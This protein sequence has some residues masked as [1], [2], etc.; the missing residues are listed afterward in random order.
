MTGR[1]RQP[2][3]WENEDQQGDMFFGSDTPDNVLTLPLQRDDIVVDFETAPV[4]LDVFRVR[5]MLRTAVEYADRNLLAEAQEL[6]DEVVASRYDGEDLNVVQQRLHSLHEVAAERARAQHAADQALDEPFT[7]RLPGRSSLSPAVLR[8]LLE[9]DDDIDHQRLWS[10]LDAT[11][12]M[13]AMAPAYAPAWVRL[14]EL[15]VALGQDDLA[16]ATL[17]ELRAIVGDED[18]DNWLNLATRSLLDPEDIDV[19]VKL[20]RAVL[21]TGDIELMDAYVSPAITQVLD[22][23]PRLA[24]ELADAFSAARP[25]AAGARTLRLRALVANGR[26]DDALAMLGSVG[27]GTVTSDVMIVKAAAA[28]AEGRDAWLVA[29]EEASVAAYQESGHIEEIRRAITAAATLIPAFEA[30]IT[31]GV[32]LFAAGDIVG[33]SRTFTADLAAQTDKHPDTAFVAAAGHALCMQRLHAAD[34][35][36]PLTTAIGQAVVQ[37]VRRYA[38]E[39]RIFPA[40]V[41]PDSLMQLLVS[42]AR[43]TDQVPEAV[44]QLMVLR[45]RLPEHL[46]IR[47]GLA[48]LLIT[49]DRVTDGVRELRY[50]AERHE[51]AGD[52]PRMI[53]AMQRMSA[54][55]PNNANVKAKLIDGFL[56]RG[57]PDEA[58]RELRQL[59]DLQVRRGRGEEGARAFARGAEIALT[60]MNVRTALDLFDRAVDADPTNLAVRH[61]TVAGCITAGQA[62]RAVTQLR[63]IVR[64]SLAA[65]DPDEAIASLHQMIALGPSDASAYHRLGEVLTSVGEYQQAR[66]VYARLAQITPNDP[67]LSAKQSA[68]AALAAMSEGQ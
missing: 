53:L 46:E 27:S 39:T 57:I 59:G 11:L 23:R 37:D 12:H 47:S 6:V 31:T 50:I 42:T 3:D 10:A 60:L 52:M 44:E 1:I 7:R 26:A 33:A 30:A 67:V 28:L 2:L 62:E 25:D 24:L 36:E 68:L 55:V 32:A 8:I 48:E 54:A 34:S 66:R 13:M 51:R 17:V 40:S 65:D 19:R 49:H 38:D 56:A 15:R 35:I 22:S 63:E 43:A 18:E 41:S 21:R 58:M 4:A 29:L 5:S 14:A 20:A 64:L 9:G 61:A 16:R 45:D